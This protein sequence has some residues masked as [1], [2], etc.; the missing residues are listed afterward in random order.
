ML[1]G[2]NQKHLNP[3]ANSEMERAKMIGRAIGQAM[4]ALTAVAW[5]LA[6]VAR[7]DDGVATPQ[8]GYGSSALWIEMTSVRAGVAFLKLH[9]AETGVSYE[10]LASRRL[11][12]PAWTAVEVITGA[13]GLDSTPVTVASKGEMN[14][15]FFRARVQAAQDRLRLELPANAFDVPGQ[16]TLVLHNTLPDVQYDVLT[17]PALAGSVWTVERS[18]FGAPGHATTVTL[19]RNNR[20]NLFARVCSGDNTAASGLWSADSMDLTADRV[21]ALFAGDATLSLTADMTRISADI[22]Q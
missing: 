22:H 12:E 17:K 16:M 11:A 7:A 21:S 6:L 5:G 15:V 1:Q 8:A 20:T 18:V 14:A 3:L 19:F 9:G 10:I 13:A 4:I 2:V